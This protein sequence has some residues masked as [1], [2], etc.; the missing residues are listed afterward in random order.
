MGVY[1]ESKTLESFY[2]SFE[3]FLEILTL[4]KNENFRLQEIEQEK[5]R[6][7]LENCCEVNVNVLMSLK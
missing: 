1:Y 7:F 6:E 3:Y 5:L 2:E 4:L